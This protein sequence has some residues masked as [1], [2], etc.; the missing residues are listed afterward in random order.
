MPNEHRRKIFLM[1]F[2]IG[3][4]III[5]AVLWVANLKNV[6]SFNRRILS[7]DSQRQWAELKNSWQGAV[8]DFN[9]N[10]EQFKD[11]PALD[12]SEVNLE[13]NK[14]ERPAWLNEVIDKAENLAASSGVAALISTSSSLVSATTT[15]E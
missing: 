5:L 15:A 8:A 1:K 12:L 9:S 11:L 14:I 13:E 4:I 7:P 3:L 10:L 2:W 6:W